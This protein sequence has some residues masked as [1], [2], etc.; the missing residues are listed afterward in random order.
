MVLLV[1]ASSSE[2][3]AEAVMMDA[4]VGNIISRARMNAKIAI[5]LLLCFLINDMILIMPW[6]ISF[7]KSLL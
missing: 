5:I 6:G 4:R 7:G 1:A 3:A 2:V